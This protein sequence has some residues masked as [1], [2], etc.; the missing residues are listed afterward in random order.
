MKSNGLHQKGVTYEKLLNKKLGIADSQANNL[1][2]KR[3]EL[4]FTKIR[5]EL[6]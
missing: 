5:R 4:V 3:S 1:L 6:Q 2:N